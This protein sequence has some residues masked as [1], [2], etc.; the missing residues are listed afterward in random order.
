MRLKKI[1]PF[2]LL[3]ILFVPLS[4]KAFWPWN[5][6]TVEQK[7]LATTES[8]LSEPTKAVAEAKYRLFE[9]SFEKKDVEAVIANQNSFWFTIDEL[10]YLFNKESISA[11]K[12]LLKNLVLS[13]EN[14]ALKVSAEFQRVVKGQFS[15][16]LKPKIT[17]T[18]LH[19]EVEKA[20]LY[21]IPI[22]SSWISRAFN[23]ELDNYLGFLYQ[24]ERYQGVDININAEMIKINLSFK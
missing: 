10:T 24:D 21:G 2:V 7:T 11:K 12:P 20:K 18:R 16:I 5:K 19:T 1:A 6:K 9:N 8:R 17:N 4:T 15:F 23:R 22:P 14:D 13:P 3:A